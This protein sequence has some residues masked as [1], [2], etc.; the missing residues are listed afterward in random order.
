MF[1]DDVNGLVRVVVVGTLAYAGLV[2]MLRISGSRTL[3]QMNAFDFIVTVALGSTLA[4]ILLSKDVAL[5]E[6]LVAFSLLIGLQFAITWLSVRVPAVNALV[7]SEPKLLFH[8]GNV[9]PGQMRTARVTA[10]EIQAAVREHG[11]GALDEVAAVVLE[12][13]GSL[14]VILSSKAFDLSALGGVRGSPPPGAVPGGR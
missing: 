6:G 4:T 7:K 1:F 5:M 12:T 8:R 3:A 14:S 2:A 13:D 10:E 11:I 9:L